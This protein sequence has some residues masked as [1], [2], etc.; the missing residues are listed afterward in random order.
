M[1]SKKT[2]R[3]Y[4][5][6]FESVT[7]NGNINSKCNV[8]MF[9]NRGACGCNIN[10]IR[11]EPGDTRTLEGHKNERDETSYSVTFDAG[12]KNPILAISRKEYLS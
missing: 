7:T 10:G 11:L 1:F 9:E 6:N 12:G 3:P 2:D 4:A 8:I 5:W